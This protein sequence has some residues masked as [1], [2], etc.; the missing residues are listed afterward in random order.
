MITMRRGFRLNEVPALV[1][2]LRIAKAMTWDGCHKIYMVM[3]QGQV[4]EFTAL[5]YTLVPPDLTLMQAWWEES[6]SLR[7][8][9]AVWTRDEPSEGFVSVID[10]FSE[11]DE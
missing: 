7:F 3:D 8:V 1:D 5:D 2:L 9:Q 11:E 4:D 6:C 10:Q